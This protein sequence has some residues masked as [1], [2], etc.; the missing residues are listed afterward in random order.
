MRLKKIKYIWI[1]LFVVLLVFFVIMAIKGREI[2][3]NVCPKV[4][5][6]RVKTVVFEGESYDCINKEC[7]RDGRVYEIYEQKGFFN[8]NTRVKA[9]E[10]NIIDSPRE[11]MVIILSGIESS[12][13]AYYAVIP[14]EGL[15]DGEAVMIEKKD[16]R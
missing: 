15:T 10:V 13:R 16:Y 5:T 12:K 6:A 3:E 2:H 4:K 14:N 8:D 11:D 1:F 9:I 7:V